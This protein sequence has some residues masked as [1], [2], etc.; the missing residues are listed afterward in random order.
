[1]V[2]KKI[3]IVD[4]E[5]R[6]QQDVNDFFGCKPKTQLNSLANCVRAGCPVIRLPLAEPDVFLTLNPDPSSMRDFT[7]MKQHKMHTPQIINL[8][9]GFCNADIYIEFTL[10]GYIH[11]HIL[12]NI[13]DKGKQ[14]IAMKRFRDIG[15][16]K[17][18]YI[19]NVENVK[20][21]CRKTIKDTRNVLLIEMPVTLGIEKDLILIGKI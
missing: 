17:I 6:E 14:A 11:Y 20:T 4:K 7:V 1:M 21:Y 5:T 9:K 18:E 12:M 8:L 13:F 19:K 10:Q 2:V 15:N 3:K 16:L